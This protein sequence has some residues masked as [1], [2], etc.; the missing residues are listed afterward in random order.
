[1][2]FQGSPADKGGIQPGDYIIKLDGKDVR[3]VQQLQL[4]VG[5]LAPGGQHTF[6]V[7]R[8]GA[9][10]E[11]KVKIEERTNDVASNNSKLWPGIFVLPLTDKIREELKLEKNI[12][13]V[14]AAPPADKSPAAVM[15]VQRNDIIT[16]LNG[17]PVKDIAAFYKLLREKAGKELWFDVRRGESNLETP[18]Y[19][20]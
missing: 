13:G 20:R 16:A 15:G 9:T 2:V 7:I 19:K 17:E 8:S 4:V 5:D 14:L 11:L 1:M 18:R 12:T 6:T 10:V 3:G